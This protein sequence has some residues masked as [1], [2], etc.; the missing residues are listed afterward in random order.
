MTLQPYSAAALSGSALIQYPPPYPLARMADEDRKIREM[1]E[2]REAEE[3]Q[4]II[5]EEAASRAQSIAGGSSSASLDELGSIQSSA[6]S[7]PQDPPS[8][9]GTSTLLIDAAL[10]ARR[11][12]REVIQHPAE[13]VKQTAFVEEEERHRQYLVA[14]GAYRRLNADSLDPVKYQQLYVLESLLVFSGKSNEPNRLC[15]P[16]TVNTLAFYCAKDKSIGKFLKEADE[17]FRVKTP[18]PSPSCHEPL[19]RHQRVYVHDNYV[20]KISSEEYDN[21]ILHGRLGMS[22]ECR[23]E[24]CPCANLG[25]LQLVSTEASRISFAKF[26][27]YSFY[28]SERLACADFECGHDGQLDHVRYW[29]F[30]SVRVAIRME[31]IDL[32]DVVAPPR[33]VKVRPDRRLELRNNE[34]DQVLGRSE[35]FFNSV[36]VRLANFKYDCIPADRQD[37]CHAALEEFK[38]RCDADRKAVARLLKSTYEHAQDSNGTEMTVVRRVLQEKSHAFDAD[39]AAFAKKVMPAEAPDMRRVSTTQLKRLFPDSAAALAVSPGR[40]TASSNLT[41]ALEIDEMSENSENSENSD[42]PLSPASSSDTSSFLPADSASTTSSGNDNDGGDASSVLSV[43]VQ[44][45]PPHLH[46][47]DASNDSSLTILTPGEGEGSISSVFPSDNLVADSAFVTPPPRSPRLPR[48]PTMYRPSVEESDLDSDSTV[49]ADGDPTLHSTG[50]LPGRTASPFIRRQLPPVLDETSAAESEMEHTQ[51]IWARR[52]TGHHVASLVDAFESTSSLGR[53][54]SS[55]KKHPS[56][57]RPNMRRAHTEKPAVPKPRV[58]RPPAFMSDGDNSCAFPFFPLPPSFRL[59]NPP[60]SHRCSQCR[61][62]ASH[63]PPT[64]RRRSSTNSHSR[65]QARQVEHQHSWLLRLHRVVILRPSPVARRRP[66]FRPRT[67]PLSQF[68]SR[69]VSSVLPPHLARKLSTAIT[70]H[71]PD[72]ESLPHPYRRRFRQRALQQPPSPHHLLLFSLDDQGQVEATAAPR[73]WRGRTQPPAHRRPY[74]PPLP[75]DG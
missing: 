69:S 18:C 7:A 8:F 29:H 19:S 47:V 67:Q 15:R 27:E 49:C 58:A 66:C 10:L 59:A 33:Q 14:W 26:L 9:G 25:R 54:P 55:G 74:L 35:A 39:W 53:S 46:V 30:E 23:H 21:S 45:E 68:V 62:L 50:T 5:E 60:L 32:R 16:P 31:R 57:S 56:P 11:P 2:A 22:I 61:R 4:R 37:D 52:K 6:A 75:P 65:S 51:P 44:I 73:R 13:L 20:V 63:G 41:P 34:Y 24:G 36:Q 40:R 12:S 48:S 42:G 1:R 64:Q 28:P 71:Q 3:T 70:P 17:D 38:A 72:D 43:D